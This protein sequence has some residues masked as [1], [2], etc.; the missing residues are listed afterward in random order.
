MFK[1]QSRWVIEKNY[2]VYYG[3]RVKP[4]FLKNKVHVSDRVICILNKLPKDLSNLERRV[5]FK[6]VKSNIVVSE[7]KYRTVPKSLNEATFCKECVA[8]DFIIPGIEYNSDG[9]CPMCE[10]K[11]EIKDFKSVLP[12]KNIIETNPNGKY[13]VAI[14]YT[15]GKDSSYLLYYLAKKLNLRV[16]AL[17]WETPYMSISALASIENAKKILKN[18]D[19]IIKKVDDNDLRK[20]YKK[21]YKLEKNNCACP[22]LAYILF[23]PLMVKEKIPYFVLGNEPVQMLNLYYNHFA[24]KSAYNQKTHKRLTT[25]INILRV[26]TFKRPLKQGQFHTLMTMRQLAYGDS[27]L[28]TI[29]GYN[30]T[31]VTHVSESVNEFDYLLKPLKL[32]IKESSKS[33][34]I[35]AFVHIDFN[36]TLGGTYNWKE[37]KEL[38]TK[39][40]GWVGPNSENKG[41]HTSCKIETC[42]ENS[43]FRSFYNKKSRVIPFSAIE[44]SL[45]SRGKE[46]NKEDALKELKQHMGFSLKEV[47]ACSLMKEYMENKKKTSE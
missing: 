44:I 37:V 18:V 30:N 1:L 38:I 39:E 22:S 13:D 36:D 15:G 17:T 31:L 21:L 19:F 45:A 24:P 33:A 43:Q 29:S 34:N 3:M 46:L 5:L 32:A 35:P 6:L 16:L 42:K 40:I 14:F 2:L 27:F 23:Y 8:N 47:K 26:I 41:L 20:M 9:L 4:Y 25:I 12:V 28:K 11:D 7:E 10:T